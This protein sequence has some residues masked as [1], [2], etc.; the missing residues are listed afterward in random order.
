VQVVLPW[1]YLE[2]QM[3]PL[4][5]NILS[6]FMRTVE[7]AKRFTGRHIFI[8]SM[9][10]LREIEHLMVSYSYNKKPFSFLRHAETTAVD[11]TPIHTIP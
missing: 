8:R 2:E 1:W 11:N 3:A 5:G 4:S 7:A 9:R 10:W 6:L